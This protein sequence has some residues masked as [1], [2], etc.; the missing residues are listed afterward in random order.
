MLGQRCL[1]IAAKG[2]TESRK[3]N[4][5]V[6]H[7]RFASVL[8]G[9]SK[10]SRG[11]ASEHCVLEC[12]FQEQNQTYFVMDLGKLV[13][14]MLLKRVV[15][16]S[17]VCW[18]GQVFYECSAAFRGFWLQSKLAEL[19]KMGRVLE[20]NVLKITMHRRDCTG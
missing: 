11:R 13:V 8:P 9:G 15:Y 20:V 6:L 10:G 17:L 4:G 12:I 5:K 14:W 3:K 19:G 16:A 7:R 1:V 2:Y 18:K